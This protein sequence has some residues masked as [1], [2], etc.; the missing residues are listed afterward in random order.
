[1]LDCLGRMQLWPRRKTMAPIKTLPA[2]GRYVLVLLTLAACAPLP[3]QREYPWQPSPNHDQRRPN[4]VIIHGTTNKTVAEAL[5]T[6]TSPEH[7]VSAHY[8][9]GRDG[10]VIQLVDEAARAW[11][12]GKSWW[13]GSTDLNS[14]SI[15]I[16]LDNTG[17]E[18]F[19]EPQIEALLAL[20]EKLRAR[21]RIPPANFIGHGEVAPGRKVDPSR[22]FPWQRL[23]QHGF[24]LWC[25]APPASVPP[26]FDPMLGLMAYGYDITQPD[27]ARQAFRRH[28]LGSDA[29]EEF[30]IDEQALIFCLLQMKILRDTEVRGASAGDRPNGEGLSH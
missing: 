3:P 18:P 21:Y 17:D 4:F 8:L 20:L 13:G 7:R 10:T 29:D 26:G 19:A 9:I 28:F 25:A 24:S 23:A 1:M 14:A 6:L 5:T 22:L 16:E 30:T 12:A 2:L 27:S 15:G 11:H